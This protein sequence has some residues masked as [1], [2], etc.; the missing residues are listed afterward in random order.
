MTPEYVTISNL[1]IDDIVLADGRSHMNILG[2]AGTHTLVGMR[3]WAD[4]LGF[5]AYCGDD[6]DPQHRA[7]LEG[8]GVDLRGVALRPGQRTARAWQLFEH[9]ERRIEIFRTSIDDFHRSKP[10]IEDIPADYLQ[11]R[12]FHLQWGA[13][14]ELSGLI[15][16]IRAANPASVMISEPSLPH[17]AGSLETNLPILTAVNIFSPDRDE[18][19]AL[20]GSSDIATI[21]DR[22]LG[23]GARVVALRMGASGSLV[24]TAAGSFY[25]APAVPPAIF[26]DVTGA[27]NA[28]CGGF[29]VGMGRGDEVALA[30]AR[31]ATSA[32]FA[33][34]QLGVP[35]FDAEKLAESGRRLEWALA[36]IE[37]RSSVTAFLPIR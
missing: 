5:V 15:A 30:A 14:D 18:A 33:I 23:I 7:F 16:Q 25:R 12:G 22:L 34:E 4:R 11:A 8:M 9:D 31:A 3:P 26:V 6:L 36:R 27:G 37:E 24:G 10:T 21:F 17:L 1:I 13:P 32:S 20:T 2:G 28:Y 19:L 29:L 35:N